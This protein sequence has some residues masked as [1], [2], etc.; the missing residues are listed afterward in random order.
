MLMEEMNWMQVEEYLKK[1][2]RLVLVTGSME[3]HGYNT[4]AT[5][6]QAAWEIAKAACEKTGVLLAPP[7]NYAFVGWAVSF[8]GTISIKPETFM[9]LIRDILRSVTAQGFKR[10]LIVNGHGQNEIA[11]FVIEDLSVENPALN[12]KFRSWYM[13]PK[14]Y[15]EIEG[16][17]MSHWDHASWLESFQWINQPVEIPKKHK[18]PINL[19][20]Y[21]T[22]GPARIREL[23]PDGVAGGPYVRDE[24]YMRKYFQTA[25]D[26][27]VEILEGSW[28]KDPPPAE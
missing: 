10:I 5:D 4:V 19:E 9:A 7:T 26:E 23:L 12:V 3:E 27:V 2:D 28:A 18:P 24:A 8:P 25:V 11:K 16:D 20:D 17:G 22:Y 21:P 14:I 6:T 1:E 15:K 13:L